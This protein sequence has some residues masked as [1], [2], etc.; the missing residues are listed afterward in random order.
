M[1]CSLEKVQNIIQDYDDLICP[2]QKQFNPELFENII[3]KI[4]RDYNNQAQIN[5]RPE[6]SNYLADSGLPSASLD[7]L[8]NNIQDH[9]IKKT[10]EKNQNLEM[11]KVGIQASIEQEK[12]GKNYLRIISK[13][14]GQIKMKF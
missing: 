11:H 3:S 1:S 9:Y 6:L 14:P 2:Y 12:P 10:K 5:I 8:A 13:N 4:L 7:I